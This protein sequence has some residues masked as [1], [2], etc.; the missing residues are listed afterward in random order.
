M[1]EVLAAGLASDGSNYY[2]KCSNHAA[3]HVTCPPLRADPTTPDS[4][5]EHLNDGNLQV[6]SSDHRPFTS[7]QKAAGTN[8]FTLIPHGVNGV[9]ERMSVVWHQGVN[10]GK[11]DPC[12][13]VAVTSANAAKYF[14]I[15]PRKV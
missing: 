10:S 8:D 1:G 9:E 3:G 15:Y 2:N 14:N 12:K 6:V 5:L 7:S 4:L 13:F 11:L